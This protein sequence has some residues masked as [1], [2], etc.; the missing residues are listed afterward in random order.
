MRH[1]HSKW[2]GVPILLLSVL[3][4]N[5]SRPV[6]AMV[7]G[8]PDFTHPNV[9]AVV[10]FHPF[11]PGN[12]LAPFCTATLISPSVAVTAGHCAFLLVEFGLPSWVS[13]DQQFDA[14]SSL[15]IAAT[16][17]PHPSF[18]PS[19]NPNDVSGVGGDPF[20]L[21]VL[22]LAEPVTDLSAAQLPAAGLLDDLKR[23]KRLPAGSLFTLVGY[24]ATGFVDGFPV[25]DGQRRAAEVPFSALFQEAAQFSAP[26]HAPSACLGDSGGPNFLNVDGVQVLTSVTWWLGTTQCSAWHRA[27]RLDTP[28]ARSFLGNFV[29]LP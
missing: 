16:P 26:H 11:L 29:I 13:F 28:Q 7:G 8:Q 2:V 18:T 5:Y 25:F 6:P 21:A 12:P 9:G 23:A 4:S 20:E 1:Q 24:G 15:L 27:Y 17:I 14:G 22:L 19:P 3:V 10:T